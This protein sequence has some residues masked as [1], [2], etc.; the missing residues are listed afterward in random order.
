MKRISEAPVFL[1]ILLACFSCTVH[2][3]SF[4][5]VERPEINVENSVIMGTVSDLQGKVLA[6]AIVNVS[7]VEVSTDENGMYRIEITTAGTYEL[8][9]SYPEKITKNSTVEVPDVKVT[10]TYVQ[11][12]SLPEYR[13]IVLQTGENEEVTE[14]IP[15]NEPEGTMTVTATVVIEETTIPKDEYL[16]LSPVYSKK[17]SEDI[18]TLKTKATTSRVENRMLIGAVIACSD[19][20]VTELP[21]PAKMSFDAVKEVQEVTKLMMYDIRNGIW[22]EIPYESF[23]NEMVFEVKYLTAYGIFGDISITEQENAQPITDFKPQAFW[24]N[25]YGKDVMHVGAVTYTT[26]VGMNLDRKQ[27]IDQLRALLL[28]KLAQDYGLGDPKDVT[29]TYNVNTDLPVGTSLELTGS[30]NLLNVKY[31]MNGKSVH[32]DVFGTVSVSGKTY[33]RVHTGGGNYTNY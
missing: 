22:V 23:D 28:E 32:A 13:T 20:S 25:Y 3:P 29:A 17:E 7:G 1:A 10:H 14:T 4:D 18:V 11:N 26:K 16:T 9:A 6:G 30:Q 15:D 8:S 31:E 19:P 21:I 12:F 2:D 33:N 27:G 24:D 5:S